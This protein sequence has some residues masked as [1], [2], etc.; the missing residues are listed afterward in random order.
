MIE[1]QLL[2]LHRESQTS[3]AFESSFE[4]VASAKTTT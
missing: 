3:A 4:R 2:A 1:R